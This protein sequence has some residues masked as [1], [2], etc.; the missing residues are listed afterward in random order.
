MKKVVFVVGVLVAV[1]VGVQAGVVA[2]WDVNGIDVN[3]GLGLATNLAPYVFS[4][5]TSETA[6]VAS[7]LTLGDGVNPST[8]A[9][10]YGFKIG[11]ADKTN[12]LAGAIASDH[13][14]E[15]ALSIDAGYALNLSSIE[16]NGGGSST[17]CSNVVLMASIDGFTAGQEIA[18]AYPANKTGG[19]DTDGSGFGGPIDLSDARYQNLTGH[20]PFRLYGWNNTSGAAV[21][22][23]R[24]LTGNDLVVHGTVVLPSDG[25]PV[26][27]L[28]SSNGARSVS[29]AFD[30]ANS[31]GYILQY[32]LDLADSNGWST[33][34]AP[35]ASNATWQIETTN[36]AGFYRATAQ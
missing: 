32:T 20:I 27:S 36:R 5:T 9:N 11:T 19:F 25:G 2:G 7:E 13:Y 8:S 18:S 15:F 17:A 1:A 35:F 12:S 24:D 31:T 21:T 28:V 14:L 22:Y 10:Q 3:D 26:L 4:A 34:S 29:A 16:I 30:E 33:V 23:L 6:H